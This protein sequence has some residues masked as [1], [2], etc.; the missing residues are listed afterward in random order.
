M[1]SLPIDPYASWIIEHTFCRLE[2][3]TGDA[4]PHLHTRALISQLSEIS[5]YGGALDISETARNTLMAA[6]AEQTL[7]PYNYL[8]SF[9]ATDLA[10]VPDVA[11]MRD[12]YGVKRLT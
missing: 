12:C 4:A 5:R 1:K 11:S 3:E 2:C 7:E 6:R 10:V 9:S 8:L